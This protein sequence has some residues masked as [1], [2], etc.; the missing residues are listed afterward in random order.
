MALRTEPSVTFSTSSTAPLNNPPA[1][2]AVTLLNNESETDV[3]LQSWQSAD[4]AAEDGREQD[5]EAD[6]NIVSWD[7]DHDPEN[8]YN[9]PLPRKFLNCGLVCTMAFIA[10]LA[11]SIFAPGVPQ[12]LEEFHSD[13]LIIASLVVSVYVLG[14]AA[15]PVIVAPL[16]EIY[17]RVIVYHVC[18]VGFVAML[19]GCALAPSL[20]SLIALRFLCGIF[21]SAPLTNGGGT[22]ADVVVQESRGGVIAI[23]SVGP[24]LGPVV[25]PVAGGFLA[26]AKGWRWTFWVLAI[27]G[28]TIALVM[29]FTL[30]ESYAPVVLERKVARL[31][32]ETGNDMLRSKLDQGLS[33]ADFFKRGLIRPLKMLAR[34]PIIVIMAVYTAITYGYLYIMFTSITDVFQKTY[35]F[36]TSTAGL[37]FLGLGIGSLVG[38]LIFSLTSDRYLKK[39][40]AEA[41][42]VA[43]ANGSSGAKVSMKPEYRLQL[44]PVG[45]AA[46]PAGL[47]IYGWTAQYGV[48]WIVPIIGTGVV[49]LGLLIVFL[50]IQTYLVDAFAIYAASALATNTI[51]RS[52]AGGLL[53]LAG[54]PLYNALGYGWGN[55]LLAFIAVA[56][57]PA[58][59][60]ILRYGEYLRNRFTIKNL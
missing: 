21:G 51:V 31:R 45:A 33:T 3:E 52:I 47:F 29:L 28:G 38:I 14:F 58:S 11:S 44:L 7:G 54:L 18:N 53:P 12:V 49:G 13:S 32:K 2:V 9:W 5:N 41:A 57:L 50:G 4:Q 56:L 17:G 20:G 27:A 1:K 22:I 10:P 46:I 30:K 39:K 60:A 25:G 16:S 23:Y 6:P 55:S 42:R 26:G 43:E 35:G 59:F 8:P 36:S 15:G 19:I 24:L 37:A 34:S 48:H 40:A